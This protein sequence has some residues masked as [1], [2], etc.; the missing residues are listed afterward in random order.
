M[1]GTEPRMGRRGVA[2]LLLALLAAGVVAS[3]P[4]TAGKFLTKKRALKLFYPKSE[5]DARFINV[6]EKAGDADTL[7]G[8]DS[9]AF[10]GASAKASDADTLDGNDSSAPGAKSAA[11]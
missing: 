3:S 1:G 11:Q 6:G 9:T 5:A 8:K 4:A 2:V 10:L 7:D